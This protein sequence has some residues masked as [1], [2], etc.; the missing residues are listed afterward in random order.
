MPSKK[1]IKGFRH[2]LANRAFAFMAVGRMAE[3]LADD[4]RGLFWKTYLDLEIFNR[5]RY[6]AAAR[7]WG[8]GVAPGI[9]TKL[10]A[11]AVSSVPKV[12]LGLLLKVVYSETL[13]YMEWLRDLS[14]EGPADSGAFLDYM[15]AQEEMQIEMMRM[16][17]QGRDA[18]IVR[19]ADEFFLKYN[20]SVMTPGEPVPPEC[21]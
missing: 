1:F 2:E 12:F 6:E 4:K 9:F 3:R 13:K 17:L 20:G 16:A 15:L 11:W 14:R 10:K 5:P 19:F 18:E 8:L 21:V 7:A